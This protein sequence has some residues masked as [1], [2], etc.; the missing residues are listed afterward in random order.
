MTGTT[1]TATTDG[2]RPS[3]A[4]TIWA[5]DEYLD[6]VRRGDFDDIDRHELVHGQV[7]PIMTRT[8]EHDFGLTE[9]CQWFDRHLPA[10]F[11]IRTQ[12]SAM[13]GN[14]VLEPDL[15]IVRGPA[16]TYLR[17]HP[18]ADDILFIVEV[19]DSSL[20]RDRKQKAMIDAENAIAVYWIVNVTDRTLEVYSH[21]VMIADACEYRDCTKYDIGDSL[22][23]VFDGINLGSIAIQTL[24]P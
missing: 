1:A 23:V 22:T 16:R 11:V 2:I 7:V 4:K 18:R 5:V 21:P 24:M 8:P 13:I 6:A 19:S 14:N 10:E 17:R 15:C 3:T 9:L 20:A 12:M